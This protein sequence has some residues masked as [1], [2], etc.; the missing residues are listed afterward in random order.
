M[1]PLRQDRIT[2]FAQRI[3]RI[4]QRIRDAA[5]RSGRNPEAIRWIAVSKTVP[6]DRIQEAVEAG[7]TRLGENYIQE[8]KKKIEVLQ[9]ASLSWHFIGHLQSNKAR[10]AVRLFDMIHTVDRLK[11]AL[12]LNRHAGSLGV[13]RAVL[14]QVNLSM[15]PTK[16][17]IPRHET[18]ALARAILDMEHLR[19][20]GLM[21]LPPFFDAPERVRPYFAALR[22]LRDRLK[23]TV[24]CEA[25]NELSMG[26]TGDFET[27]VEEGATLVRIGTAC[28]GERP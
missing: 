11:L 16:S 12:E 22:Q 18:P 14:I 6:T 7:V 21:T 8:A 24:S 2:L 25:L 13:V 27:A 10:E 17:G 15:E 26:M 4:E 9:N 19:L 23:E 28:F 20:R 5:L 1:E 3:A